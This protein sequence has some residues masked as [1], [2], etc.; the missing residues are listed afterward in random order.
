[1]THLGKNDKAS[2]KF[3]VVAA[4]ADT[5]PKTV[6]VDDLPAIVLGPGTHDAFSFSVTLSEKPK[7]FKKG[8]IDASNATVSGDPVFAGTVRLMPRILPSPV[9]SFISIS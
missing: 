9:N 3:D 8:H 6:S 2:L 4:L 1:M 5:D 7:E